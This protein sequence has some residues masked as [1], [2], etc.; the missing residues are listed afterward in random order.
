MS[1]EPKGRASKGRRSKGR[2][3]KGRSSNRN[4][5]N[6]KKN[7]Q[8]LLEAM[9][10]GGSKFCDTAS[11][12]DTLLSTLARLGYSDRVKKEMKLKRKS[13]MEFERKMR[14]VMSGQYKSPAPYGDGEQSPLKGDAATIL[15]NQWA[16]GMDY[17]VMEPRFTHLSNWMRNLFKGDYAAM[18]KEIDKTDKKDLTN[19]LERRES[20]L[21]VS[22]IFHVII[23]ARSLCG[24]HVEFAQ[25]R[26][27]I[28]KKN[29]NHLGCFLK[30]INLGARIDAKD[31]AGYTP[32]HHTLTKFANDV[33]RKMCNILLKRKVSPNIQNRFGATPLFEPTMCG[34][35]DSIKILVEYGADSSLCDNDETNCDK[36]ARAYPNIQRLFAR[37]NQ[38]RCKIMRKEAKKKAGGSFRK[39]S[40]CEESKG[41]MRCSACFIVWYCSRN[42]QR[43]HWAEHKVKCKKT[44]AL[45]IPVKLEKTNKSGYALNWMTDDTF[46]TENVNIP[47]KTQFVVKVQVP[48]NESG[49]AADLMVYNKDRSC[50]GRLKATEPA[51]NKLVGNIKKHGISGVKGFFYATWDQKAGLKI[52]TSNIQPMKTW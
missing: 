30:L 35:I 26:K 12:K 6:E 46:S 1:S 32:L 27:A 36:L 34:H 41:T 23:G 21:N 17:N 37:S 15:R 31:I 20:L 22:A 3:S 49:I 38:V 11:N 47:S 19:L 40:L 42:C 2:H 8:D 51:Y 4:N 10:K 29:M 52:N 25:F 13:D 45:Y 39:C 9:N 44:K 33:T 14:L 5:S 43:S 50:I 16:S 48:L 7:I 28:K 18:M 24:D